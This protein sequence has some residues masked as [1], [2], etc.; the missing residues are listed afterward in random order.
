MVANLIIKF[1]RPVHL[2]N[3][4]TLKKKT[5]PGFSGMW[6]SF[7]AAHGFSEPRHF[8][9]CIGPCTLVQEILGELASFELSLL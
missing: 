5:I 3:S 4:P 6:S 2:K 9:G 7:H 1:Y 8:L